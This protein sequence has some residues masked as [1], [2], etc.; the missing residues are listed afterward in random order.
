M[1]Q[2]HKARVG[3]TVMCSKCNKKDGEG[4]KGG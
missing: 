4:D 2:I 3:D 1:G